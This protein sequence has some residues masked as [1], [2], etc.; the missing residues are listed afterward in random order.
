MWWIG[1]ELKGSGPGYFGSKITA[2]AFR[3]QINHEN[4]LRA[5][6]HC[7]RN[8]TQDL[9]NVEC[10][11]VNCSIWWHTWCGPS[12]YWVNSSCQKVVLTIES[13]ALTLNSQSEFDSQDSHYFSKYH[14]LLD[15]CNGDKLFSVTFLPY[16]QTTFSRISR[17]LLRYN[18]KGI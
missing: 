7:T 14:Q 3:G 9:L 12:Q 4:S 16:V 10:F 8:Q 15:P 2:F 11:L 18:T 6:N 17:M 1:K 13:T 5:M